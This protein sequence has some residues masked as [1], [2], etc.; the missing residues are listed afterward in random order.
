MSS[1]DSEFNS[2]SNGSIF[3]HRTYLKK[4]IWIFSPVNKKNKDKGKQIC[5]ACLMNKSIVIWYRIKFWIGW[6]HFYEPSMLLKK[7]YMN[8][9]FVVLASHPYWILKSERNQKN[10]R[11]SKE[12][13][14]ML[15]ISSSKI[16][17][18]LKCASLYGKTRQNEIL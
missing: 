8:Y 6:T 12:T 10:P 18:W 9:R 17:L 11:K 1:L 14:R 7:F 2:A 5:K 15:Y 13:K 4:I 16:V 3:I